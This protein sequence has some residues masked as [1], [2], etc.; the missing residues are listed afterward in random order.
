MNWAATTTR[1][2]GD[3][4]RAHR[5]AAFVWCLPALG[6][7]LIAVVYLVRTARRKA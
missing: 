7:L 4:D 1:R 3:A 5:E 2:R 6:C